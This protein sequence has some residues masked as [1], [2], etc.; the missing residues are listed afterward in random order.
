MPAAE[1]GLN[2]GI[3][4][5]GVD[6]DAVQRGQVAVTPGSV[7][8]HAS[9]EAEIFLLDAA[10]GGRHTPVR[11]GYMPQLWFGA[12]DVTASLD[13]GE[14]VLLDPGARGTVELLLQRAVAMEAGMRFAIREGSRTFGAGIVQRVW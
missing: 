14:G 8:P 10:D 5:R 4:L 2:V 3:L 1:A 12:T 11:S 7:R 13:L 9:A 6:K